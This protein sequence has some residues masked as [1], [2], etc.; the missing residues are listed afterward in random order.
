MRNTRYVFHVLLRSNVA[1]ASPGRS[2]SVRLTA[3]PD[4]T[5]NNENSNCNP[6]KRDR[7][8]PVRYEVSGNLEV[9]FQFCDV[10]I[11]ALALFVD[12]FSYLNRFFA[13]RTF[14]FAAAIVC[15]A[16]KV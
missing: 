14:S 2:S 6:D 15:S 5:N 13:H 7:T 8:S 3:R 12:M 10:H 1:T 16:L 4:F 11:K 9:A